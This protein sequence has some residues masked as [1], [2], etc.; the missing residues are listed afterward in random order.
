MRVWVFN[1][2]VRRFNRSIVSTRLPDR[3]DV[4][5]NRQHTDDWAYFFM[6]SAAFISI[7][8]VQQVCVN[9]AYV[10]FTFCVATLIRC[11][12]SKNSFSST[13]CEPEYANNRRIICKYMRS[14]N[15]PFV[16]SLFTIGSVWSESGIELWTQH[17]YWN[18]CAYQILCAQCVI[19][20]LVSILVVFHVLWMVLFLM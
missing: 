7:C 16:L 4:F 14:P 9:G 5:V 11:T 19:M 18:H 3:I 8:F 10:V 6:M 12:F 1:F 15:V 13:F 17:T 20:L 2:K